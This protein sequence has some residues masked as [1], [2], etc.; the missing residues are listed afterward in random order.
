M[1]N[2]RVGMGYDVHQLEEGRDFWMGGIKLPATKGAVG[3]SDA[4]VLIHAICDALLGA[5]NMR[6]IGFHFK[7]TDDRWKGMDSKFFL[8]EVTRMITEK[9]WKVG[10]VDCTICLEKPK[11]GPH[12]D[13]MKKTM[14][15]LMNVTEEE[16]AIK[17]TTTETLGYVGRE[18]GVN[19]SAVVLI[20]K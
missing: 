15:P 4:D 9:G 14:A 12:I 17:A 10:N 6:D 1:T 19:A 7:N 2:I 8:K 13:A 16:I 11:I 18:E 5:A 20:Y 3:H